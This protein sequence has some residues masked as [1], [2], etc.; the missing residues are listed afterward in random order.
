MVLAVNGV[1][2]LVSAALLSTVRFGSPVDSPAE[3]DSTP[4]DESIWAATVE[5]ARSAQRIPGVATLLALCTAAMFA[6]ALM[7]VAEPLLATGALAAGNT[8]FSILVAVYGAAMAAGSLVLAR[9]GS[10]V[11]RLRGWLLLGLG[12]QGAGMLGSAIAPSL[13]FAIAT[14]ALTGAS[15]ALSAGPEVRLVQELV[16][17]RLLGRVF[18]LRDVLADLAYV[19]AFVSAGIVLEAL[20]VRAVFALGGAALLALATAG[21]LRFHPGRSSADQLAAVAEAA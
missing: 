12:L 7:N 5:G 20:G 16:G 15:N 14:F 18:G 10:S 6:G 9:A 1:T 13:P 11:S 3:A 19:L 8:G 4:S 2:F 17:A 21:Y